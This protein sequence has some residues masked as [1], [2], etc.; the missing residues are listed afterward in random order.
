[1]SEALVIEGHQ[2]AVDVYHTKRKG[3]F[4]GWDVNSALNQVDFLCATAKLQ[5]HKGCHL[6]TYRDIAL[7]RDTFLLLLNVC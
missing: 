5:S 4:D 7:V 3:I 2:F 6:A 1:M